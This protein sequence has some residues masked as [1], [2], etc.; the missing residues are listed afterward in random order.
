MTLQHFRGQFCLWAIQTHGGSA[1]FRAWHAE[2]GR[3][4]FRNAVA[5]HRD[6]LWNQTY[7][8]PEAEPMRNLTV[9]KEVRELSVIPPAVPPSKVEY[10]TVVTPYVYDCFSRV[11]PDGLKKVTTANR[12]SHMTS[13]VFDRVEVPVSRRLPRDKSGRIPPQEVNPQVGDV[14]AFAPDKDTKWRGAGNAWYAY[15]QAIHGD[16]LSLIWLY[17]P[18]DTILAGEKYPYQNE[19]IPSVLSSRHRRVLTIQ[20]FFSDHCNC[21][22]SETSIDEVLY[23]LPTSFFVGPNESNFEF[24]IRQ[25][26]RTFRDPTNPS[27]ITLKL[28]DLKGCACTSETIS[29][30]EV[31][32]SKYS[33]GDTVL[34][35]I[36]SMLEP[37]EIIC[38]DNGSQRVELRVLQ[39][40]N[41][42]EPARPNELLYTHTTTWTKPGLIKRR[43]QIRMKSDNLPASYTRDGAGTVP[44]NLSVT[45]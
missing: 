28:S 10:K 20:L 15:I 35:E 37:A 21:N 43:C 26:Y 9:W 11:W 8:L 2:F 17:T 19:V 18:S 22:E 25:K 31:V 40:R 45:D 42:L 5:V 27:F 33:T 7:N 6:W 12:N 23:I 30:F 29:D 44:R 39:R 36:C 34:V 24:F 4:D 32:K 16:K 3:D 13:L 41:R 1:S 14:V 38:F